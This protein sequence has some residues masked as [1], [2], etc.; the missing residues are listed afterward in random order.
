MKTPEKPKP[1]R[2]CEDWKSKALEI[3]ERDYWGDASVDDSRLVTTCHRLR[4]KPLA[5]FEVED[6]RILIGQNIGLD[7]LIP[8]AMKVLEKNILAEGDFYSGDLLKA[9]LTSDEEYWKS[10][11]SD[12]KELIALFKANLTSIKEE[13]EVFPT[14]KEILAAFGAFEQI[15]LET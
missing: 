4:K 1:I 7:F 6:Y 8:L 13:A 9:V 12:W 15:K 2:D 5:E 14:G 10:H 11:R 3:L